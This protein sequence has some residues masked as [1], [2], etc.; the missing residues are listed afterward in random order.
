MSLAERRRRTHLQ[1]VPAHCGIPKNE[2]EDSPAKEAS[3][4]DQSST[5]LEASSVAHAAAQPW[6]LTWPDGWFKNILRERLPG[7]LCR[8]CREEAETPRLLQ[9]PSPRGPRLWIFG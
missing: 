8:V 9:C 4:L 6:R 1:W 5:L 2:Q 3:A 7:P